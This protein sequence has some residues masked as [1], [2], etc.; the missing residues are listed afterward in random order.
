[1]NVHAREGGPRRDGLRKWWSRQGAGR[2]TVVIVLGILIV[3]LALGLATSEPSPPENAPAE[4]PAPL[5]SPAGA[6]L[7]LWN[8]S[9]SNPAREQ[10]SAYAK[11]SS[12]VATVGFSS[13]LPD[14]CQIVVAAQDLGEG[15]AEVYRQYGDFDG[16]EPAYVRIS[17]GT[18]TELPPSAKEWN[19]RGR[20][21][22]TILLGFP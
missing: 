16:E 17:G 20:P 4:F 21:D 10:V 6:C 12:L 1:M 5:P 18:V 7:A 13:D 22:G 11:Y 2:Q 9:N 14:K 15:R 19:A 3:P 8:L